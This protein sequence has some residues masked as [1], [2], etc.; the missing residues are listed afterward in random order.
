MTGDHGVHRGLEGVEVEA[1]GDGDLQVGDV[2]VGAAPGVGEHLVQ[3]A[4]LEHGERVG[5]GEVVGQPAGVGGVELGEG[6]DGLGG[7]D[8]RRWPARPGP[9]G[10]GRGR[11]RDGE[12]ESGETAEAHQAQGEDGV[13]AEV[14]EAVGAAD[15]VDAEDLAPDAGQRLAR[16]RSAAA[17]SARRPAAP[18]SGGGQRGAV[19]L[20]VGGQRQPRRAATNAAGTM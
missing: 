6:G 7:V 13:A 16:R 1:L 8:R 3:H 2:V 19:E 10:C 20:A 5:V 18:A 12:A 11:R 14:E 4:R 15:V 17:T 9:R